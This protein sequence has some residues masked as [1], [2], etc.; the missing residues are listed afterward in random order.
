MQKSWRKFSA[1]A[2]IFLFSLSNSPADSSG[3]VKLAVPE[4]KAVSYFDGIEADVLSDV[5]KG[6]PESLRN[7][8][9]KL[10]RNKNSM[11]ENEQVL[12][13][14]AVSIM[15]LCWK[16][17][18]F[19]DDTTGQN[20]KNDYTGA[21]S[22]SRNGFYDSPLG[23]KDFFGYVLP[24]LVL[25]ASETRSDYYDESEKS[26]LAA[27]SMRPDSLLANY[28]Y[29]VL[30]RR[31][32]DFKTANDYFGR[33]FDIA[34]NC[35]E[36]SFAY[37]E[38][39]MSLSDPGTAFT[40]AEKMLRSYPQ[41]KNLLKLCAE[42]AFAASDFVNAELYVSRVLQ[43]EPENSNYLLFRA[44]ILVR[45]GEYIR[46]ASLLDAYARKD[47]VS[48]DYLVLRFTVQKN[49]NRNTAAAMT[50]IENALSLY[51][52]DSEIIL[53]AASLAS[54]TGSKI[55]GK[56]GEELADMVLE[57]E[58]ENF[59]ALQIKISSMVA[60]KK[61][62]DAYKASSELLKKDDVPNSVLFSHIK[63][64]LSAGKKDEAWKYA[65]KLYSANGSDEE[66][67]QSY[68]DVL[69]STGR[70][71][72]A[73]KLITQLLPSSATR[74]KS[75]LYYER[76]FLAS[77]ENAVLADL[78]SSLT[79]NPRN[80]DAL[81]RLYKIYYN[82]KEY[83]KAQYYLKQVVALSPKDESLLKLNRELENLL[84]N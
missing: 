31:K 83:R 37:A 43:L 59:D 60:A 30:C 22:S 18:K 63:I 52:D 44:R 35:Y 55:G 67:L 50:T 25:V 28:L 5:E 75:F 29:G 78:R 4:R 80:S 21:I 13:Y 58:P 3:A 23:E 16:S 32:K 66:V 27:L 64:C 65:S 1:F 14:I 8:I 79:A 45:K 12:H 71:A 11:A 56:S 36:C 20:F 10:K 69:V 61:W 57:K 81:F 19:T 17:E 82:K 84:K 46:A 2:C 62:N 77:G 39:F 41:N 73:S 53:S 24:S 76:S 74:M 49:W 54:E 42:S 26:L 15:Q 51:P 72:E 47:S 70:T 68:I 38:S 48:R 34:Q 9:S 6:S 33:A 40:L 7:A